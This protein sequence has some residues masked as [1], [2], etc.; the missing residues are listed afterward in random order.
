MIQLSSWWN[1]W[2][3]S[4]FVSPP[5]LHSGKEGSRRQGWWKQFSQGGEQQTWNV[6]LLGKQVWSLKEA[7]KPD[8]FQTTSSEHSK[9]QQ[10]KHPIVSWACFYM[11][12][13]YSVEN[14]QTH[15]EQR[16][17]FP[18]PAKDNQCLRSK[19]PTVPTKS[20]NIQK[21][22]VNFM[23]KISCFST[24][25]F[26]KWLQFAAVFVGGNL[27]SP[28]YPELNGTSQEP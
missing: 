8:F 4:P 18:M 22:K 25:S 13:C 7:E 14:L 26:S 1:D 9:K 27:G 3:C 12:T 15:A 6:S 5:H 19:P 17:H 28:K 20:I 24:P 23:I 16:L 21:I 11:S 10:V 2:N